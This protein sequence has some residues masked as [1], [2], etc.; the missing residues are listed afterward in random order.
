M[1]RLLISAALKSSGKTTVALGLC[2][3]LAERGVRVQPFKKGPDYID[4]MWL[5]R[6][7]G[8]TCRNL[9]FFTMSEREIAAEFSRHAADAD[10]ALIEGNKGLHDGLDRDG[11]DSSA[12]LAK[13]L[14]APVLLVVDVQG[15]I[16]GVAPLLLGYQAFDANVRIAGVILN[17]IG[18]ARQEGK[19]R[20]VVERYTD[21]PVLGAI[22]RDPAL[23]IAERHLGLVPANEAAGAAEKIASVAR[24]IAGAVDLDRVRALAAKAAPTAPVRTPAPAAAPG[25]RAALTAPA[26]RIAVARDAAFGFYYPGDLEALEAA[27]AELRPFDALRD[28][29]LPEA[30]ALFIGGGFPETQMAALEGNRSLRREIRAAIE[31]GLPAYAECGGLLYLC[32]SLTWRGER[33]D[34]VG[35]IAAD[36]VM[37]ARPQGRG[38]VRLEETGD[39]P[40]PPRQAPAGPIPAHEFHYSSLENLGEG[41]RYA[42]RVARGTGIDGRHDGI[43]YKNLLASF[44]HLRDLESNRWTERFV[45]FV[46]ACGQGAALP[47][48]PRRFT[49]Q[50]RSTTRPTTRPARRS[51]SADVA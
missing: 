21:I 17:K 15:M 46:R 40:W 26:L 25:T 27:G 13:L 32:R 39:G 6:A 34:M 28:P 30:D 42:Y 31:G 45:A 47:R 11:A 37:H 18:G 20:A 35:A 51:S 12:A 4:P 23:E 3:S 9:D 50:G 5:G 44:A 10:I 29:R 48:P 33:R 19:L 8:R 43:V 49:A 2:A 14:S 24:T 16:R 7:A 22:G 36:A 1:S 41:V 38:Y